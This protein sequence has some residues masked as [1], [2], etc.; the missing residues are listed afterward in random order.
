MTANPGDAR[1]AKRR[2]DK[3]LI[4]AMRRNSEATIS[5]LATAIS[6]SKT[7][8]VEGLHRLR[9][10]GLAESAEG[11]GGLPS[12][13]RSRQLRHRVA[14]QPRGVAIRRASDRASWPMNAP[15]SR[16]CAAPP[17]PRFPRRYR[18]PHHVLA[19]R[20]IGGQRMKLWDLVTRQILAF[21]MLSTLPAKI[22]P[23]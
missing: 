22:W 1:R 11:I 21:Q 4:E 2:D 13:P 19:L 14:G 23:G 5:E 18:S 15:G 6:K 7:S 8:A 16:S 12:R 9:D 17:R 3:A 20:D 10:T